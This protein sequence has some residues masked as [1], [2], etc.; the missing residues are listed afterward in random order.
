MQLGVVPDDTVAICMERSFDWIVAAP[1]I[2]RAGAGYV[3]LDPAQPDSRLRFATNDSNAT[4][5]VARAL[6]E[7]HDFR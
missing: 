1:A 5:L 3:P 4:I 7:L 6:S 2:M